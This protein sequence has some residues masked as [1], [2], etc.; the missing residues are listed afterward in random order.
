[1][2]QPIDRS[3]PVCN[4]PHFLEHNGVLARALVHERIGVANSNG[5]IHQLGGFHAVF[6][7]LAAVRHVLIAIPLDERSTRDEWQPARRAPFNPPIVATPFHPYLLLAVV[8]R[9]R[10]ST[11]VVKDTL[12][13]EKA[14]VPA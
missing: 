4:A 9:V 10:G 11:V 8:H 12:D 5:E 14:G 13:E 2:R 3:N 7:Q 1:M 6:P